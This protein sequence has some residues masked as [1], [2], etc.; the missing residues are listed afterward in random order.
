MGLRLIGLGTAVAVLVL[1]GCESGDDEGYRGGGTATGNMGNINDGPASAIGGG[2]GGTAGMGGFQDGTGGGPVDLGG[3]D[4]CNQDVDVVFVI[5]VSGSMIAPLT[6]LENEVGQVDAALQAKNLPSPPQYGLV[7]FVDDV[8]VTNGGQPYADIGALKA[9]VNAEIMMA[10]TQ[11]FR[12]ADRA[13]AERN[14]SWP[15]NTLDG[16]HAAATQFAWR[17]AAT[18][19]RT[20][21]H[22]TDA[23]FWNVGDV[24]SAEGDPMNLEPPGGCSV[25]YTA[26]PGDCTM[27][28]SAH[29][30]MET[31]DALRAA[32]IWTN[33]FSALTGGPP[34][35]GYA[36][37][38]ASH[39]PYRGE[40]VDVSFGF[41]KP[42]NGMPSIANSTG[43]LAWNIDDVFDGV[44]SLATPINDAIADAQCMEYP[45]IVVE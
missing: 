30:Y 34:P 25:T 33:T 36:N 22:F 1:G 27:V 15:E 6:T 21:I 5:D 10:N 41:H 3:G 13:I 2:G 7:I 37:G 23:S 4:N 18:T 28:R 20:V 11:A 24:S 39:G 45:P 16:L 17:P 12:Q 44:I 32:S 29:S 8:V 40:L 19:L 31:I 42:Y 14:A 9:A 43:G 38:P 26:Q 35:N